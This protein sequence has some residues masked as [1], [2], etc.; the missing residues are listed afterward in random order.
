MP[1]SLL[2]PVASSDPEQVLRQ[3]WNNGVIEAKKNKDVLVLAVPLQTIPAT[4]EAL[5]DLL[6][7][8]KKDSL[9]AAFHIVYVQQVSDGT[10]GWSKAPYEAKSAK[11]NDSMKAPTLPLYTTGNNNEVVVW[12]YEKTMNP[13]NKGPR[14]SHQ[15][16]FVLPTKTVMRFFLRPNNLEDDL[17]LFDPDMREIPAMTPMILRLTGVNKD[18]AEKGYG[19]KIK[20]M[21]VLPQ[22]VLA[23]YMPYFCKQVSELIA[24][25]EPFQFAEQ[26]GEPGDEGE[27]GQDKMMPES[28]NACLR[29]VVDVKMVKRTPLCLKLNASAYVWEGE[30]GNDRLEIIESGLPSEIGDTLMLPSKVLLECMHTNTVDRALRLFEVCI[31]HNAVDVLVAPTFDKT[32][33][34]QRP[35]PQVYHIRVDWNQALWL[36]HLKASC[37]GDIATSLPFNDTLKM[38][39]GKPIPVDGSLS[40]NMASDNVLQWYNPNS[41]RTTATE[42]GGE[43]QTFIVFELEMHKIQVHDAEENGFRPQVKFMMDAGTG[44]FYHIRVFEVD[45]PRFEENIGFAD[46]KDPKLLLAWQLRPNAQQHSSVGSSTTRKRKQRTYDLSDVQYASGIAAAAP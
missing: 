32:V 35:Q 15:W 40:V 19:L 42:D 23:H 12:A 18:A 25:N 46:S 14:A 2:Q 27:E 24:V 6:A 37:M 28:K 21:Q 5:G 7:E 38:C 16:S 26:G 8:R 17:M 10:Y 30:D 3:Q 29:K 9:N 45:A 4:S 34:G 36:S 33:M 1:T 11:K 41:L 43:K 22:E 44:W 20:Q 31:A 39:Y 13:M